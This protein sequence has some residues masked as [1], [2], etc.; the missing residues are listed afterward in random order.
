MALRASCHQL[1]WDSV[2]RVTSI[3]E[4]PCPLSLPLR[5]P[6]TP[7]TPKAPADGKLPPPTHLGVAGT[8]Q[9][10][11][12]M[13]R[14]PS[15]SSLPGLTSQTKTWKEWG[16]WASGQASPRTLERG[17]TSRK[18]SVQVQ[19]PSPREL[20]LSGAT[21]ERRNTG[22]CGATQEARSHRSQA[23]FQ[24]HPLSLPCFYAGG[25]MPEIPPWGPVRYDSQVLLAATAQ[26]QHLARGPCVLELSSCT[27]WARG[28]VKTQIQGGL[29][30]SLSFFISKKER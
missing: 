21:K 18:G 25:W 16:R 14:L 7:L 23:Q 27:P 12:Q 17:E 30:P 20:S 6:K 24:K 1:K 10:G 8:S 15:L 11:Q 29:K 9:D 28:G 2:P 22:L 4:V 3:E 13:A 26:V 19:A 5:G